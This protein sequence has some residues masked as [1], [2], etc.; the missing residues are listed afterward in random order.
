CDN[1]G[2]IP[3]DIIENIFDPYFSTKDD[4]NGTGLG[5]Y[6]SKTIVEEHH[7]G[8]ISVEN[9]N[10]IEGTGAGACFIIELFEE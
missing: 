7:N 1:G 8:K 9:K 4:K 2:G 3:E 10:E 5:L 6:M